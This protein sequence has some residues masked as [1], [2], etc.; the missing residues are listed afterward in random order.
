MTIDEPSSTVRVKPELVEE[1]LWREFNGC[2]N[3]MIITKNGRCMFPLLRLRFL[4]HSPRPPEEGEKGIEIGGSVEYRVAIEMQPVDGLKWKWRGSRW[5]PLLSSSYPMASDKEDS[6]LV[7]YETQASPE[8]RKTALISGKELLENG[9]DLSRLK[10]TNRP[11]TQAEVA[12]RSPVIVLRS[13]RR[14]QPRIHLLPS[15]ASPR[16]QALPQIISLQ[17]TEFIAVTHYQNDR[18]T[19]LKKSY[20][21]HAKGFVLPSS[22]EAA[23]QEAEEERWTMRPVQGRRKRIR[24]HPV[25]SPLS[26]ENLPASVMPSDEEELAGTIALQ[27]LSSSN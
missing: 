17:E 7:L 10:L 27:G 6:A 13:F 20:N 22:D 16:P 9:L 26:Q 25:S 19:L 15:P 14:Y 12:N 2:Q 5:S 1:G 8:T 21:P 18:I 11:L 24:V 4:P 3:E 23:P